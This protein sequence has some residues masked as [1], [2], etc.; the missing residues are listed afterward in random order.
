MAQMVR[1]DGGVPYC[2][3]R[4]ATGFENLDDHKATR[5]LE[6]GQFAGDI[7]RGY[8]WA[9]QM[10]PE[11]RQQHRERDIADLLIRALAKQPDSCRR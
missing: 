4:N 9:V 11:S 7:C 10:R 6:R 5:N 3:T 8:S 1:L 2:T